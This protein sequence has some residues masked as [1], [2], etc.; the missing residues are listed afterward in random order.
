MAWRN[1]WFDDKEPE[2][3]PFIET[4]KEK[5]CYYVDDLHPSY[6]DLEPGYWERVWTVATKNGVERASETFKEVDGQWQQV[7]LGN[8]GVVFFEGPCNQDNSE[9]YKI[10]PP[11]EDWGTDANRISAGSI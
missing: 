8:E 4:L 6:R 11:Q 9:K 10:G 7:M 3:H 1:P 5:G 2:V